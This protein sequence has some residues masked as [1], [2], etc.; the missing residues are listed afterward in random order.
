MLARIE[1]TFL[2]TFFDSLYSSIGFSRFYEQHIIVE[3]VCVVVRR[4]N[5]FANCIDTSGFLYDIKRLGDHV[6]SIIDNEAGGHIEQAFC[7]YEGCILICDNPIL[8]PH[9]RLKDLRQYV[10]SHHAI[11][12]PLGGIIHYHMKE[13]ELNDNDIRSLKS[14]AKGMKDHGIGELIGFVASQH[15]PR[16]SLRLLDYGKGRFKEQLFSEYHD[17]KFLITGK[18]FKGDTASDIQIVGP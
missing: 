8:F 3:P 10:K 17:G 7:M 2:K 4:G 14:F 11:G 6:A 5:L 18:L 12:K 13:P 1:S 9:D 16:E 15:D